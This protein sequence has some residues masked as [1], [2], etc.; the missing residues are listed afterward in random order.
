MQAH[1]ALP[2]FSTDGDEMDD[3]CSN[4]ELEH[5]AADGDNFSTAGN[6]DDPTGGNDSRAAGLSYKLR[7][8][9]S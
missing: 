5:D 9:P 2:L 7:P 8:F 4:H 6:R 1:D 3:S